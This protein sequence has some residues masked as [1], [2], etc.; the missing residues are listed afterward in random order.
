MLS[1]F[2]CSWDCV[3][4]MMYMYMDLNHC[5][6]RCISGWPFSIHHMYWYWYIGNKSAT[7][8]VSACIKSLTL[9]ILSKQTHCFIILSR[10][11]SQFNLTE[12]RL[13]TMHAGSDSWL[14]LVS[15]RWLKWRCRYEKSTTPRG[16]GYNY[17]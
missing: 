1:R 12:P 5:T 7:C 4:T 2:D 10:S 16:Q 17:Q 11:K 6:Q 9:P 13:T 15:A 8:L 14:Q 3:K